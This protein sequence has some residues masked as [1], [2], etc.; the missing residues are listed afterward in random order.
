MHSRG[1]V[2]ASLAAAVLCCVASA[3]QAGVLIT[4][5]KASQQMSVAIDGVPRYTWPVSTGRS[6][7]ATP[8]GTFTPFRLE[9]D[10]YSKEWDEAPMPHSIFFT[11]VGHAIHGTYET[12][13]LGAAVSHGCV[14]L[15]PQNAATLFALVKAEGLSNTRVVLTGQ[16][17]PLV[18]GR[19]AQRQ[20]AREPVEL[21]QYRSQE[22]YQDQYQP[23]YGRPAHQPYGAQPQYGQPHAA[24]P[25]YQQSPYG[26]QPYDPRSQ[27][28]DPR[29]GPRY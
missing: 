27:T 18:A 16:A 26:M 29:F 11:K 6:G 7:Y 5:N 4:I 20:S 21:Q 3:A 13:R 8:S 2:F 28:Y 15:A 24:H 14:R 10:H 17:P 12:K 22:R 1:G 25:R 23:P 19:P 9:E